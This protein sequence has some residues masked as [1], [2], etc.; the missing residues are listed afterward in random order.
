MS[1]LFMNAPAITCFVV[2][3]IMAIND[4]SGWGW[5]FCGGLLT[6]MCDFKGKKP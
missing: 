1:I 2:A 5:F 3:G 4:K 6:T